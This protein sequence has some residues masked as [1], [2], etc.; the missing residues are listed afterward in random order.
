MRSQVSLS[1]ERYGGPIT[2]RMPSVSSASWFETTLASIGDAVIVTD[3]RGRVISANKVAQAVVKWPDSEIVGKDLDEVFRIVNE[4]SRAKV[5]SPVA[6]VLREGSI[7]GL[8]NHTILI[9]SDGTEVPIDDSAAPIRGASGAVLG[10]VLVF[11]DI[12]SRRRAE[13]AAPPPGHSLYF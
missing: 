5:E 2:Q 12:T 6:R 4:F 1:G 11:R 3:A 10:T 13:D 9:A 7:V 8:A